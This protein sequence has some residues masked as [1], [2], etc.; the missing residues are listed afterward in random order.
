MA[1]TRVTPKRRPSLA[2]LAD[3]V[4]TEAFRESFDKFLRS[5]VKHHP[6]SRNWLQQF[7][8][9]WRAEIEWRSRACER[10][11]GAREHARNRRRLRSML[12]EVRS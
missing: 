8:R 2:Q 10:G 6:K 7:L 11:R 9:A 5:T 3:R 12:P 4:V 1:T